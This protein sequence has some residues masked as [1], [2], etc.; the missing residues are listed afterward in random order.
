[1]TPQKK[2]LVVDDDTLVRAT[3]CT[4]LRDCGYL[5]FEADNGNAAIDHLTRNGAPDLVITDMIMPQ[6][7]GLE[8]IQFIKD[9]YPSL[10]IIAVSGGSANKSGNLLETAK[11]LGASAILQKP[12]NFEE[13]E[14]V[15]AM[16]V[17]SFCDDVSWD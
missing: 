4:N 7:N 3:I 14:G 8:V 15:V 1:M 17:D 11:N 10:S 12:L 16:L 6:K 9:K 13:F 2:I 5:V